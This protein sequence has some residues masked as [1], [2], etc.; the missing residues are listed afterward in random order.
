MLFRSKSQINS[1]ISELNGKKIEKF[2]FKNKKD[3]L[4]A[5]ESIKKKNYTV[6]DI[7]SK[8]Y[9]RNPSGPFTTST[10]QQSASSKLG[11]GASRTMQIAQRLYQGIDVEGDTI[12][13]ITYMRTDGT[14]I[15]KDAVDS[16]RSYILEN[17]GKDYLPEN[18]L[19]YSGK[20]AKNAQ[21][22]HEAI[23][24]TEIN[25]NPESLKSYL[26]SDQYKLYNLKTKSYHYSYTLVLN[27][28]NY[29]K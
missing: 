25:R 1:N 8:I 22:A 23:R 10:L 9:N 17:Y 6:T 15:S 11:F 14:N 19:N 2:S 5:I 16:F 4:E 28:L 18:A 29:N 12:G 21:E 13:L 20:K 3:I 7:S 26:S 27:L 24:P